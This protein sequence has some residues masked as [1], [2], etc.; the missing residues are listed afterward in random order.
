MPVVELTNVEMVA[1]TDTIEMDNGAL[2]GVGVRCDG[3]FQGKGCR[4]WYY[5]NLN[6][7]ESQVV[8]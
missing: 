7:V 1:I 3:R 4:I 5:F 6:H 2:A 8:K